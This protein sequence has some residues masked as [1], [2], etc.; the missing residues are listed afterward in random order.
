MKRIILST[1]ALAALTSTAFAQEFYGS[2]KAQ[3]ES[4]SFGN[5][6]DMQ[7]FTSDVTIGVSGIGV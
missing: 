2:G 1:V 4:L 3:Y 5:D 7:V 6:L